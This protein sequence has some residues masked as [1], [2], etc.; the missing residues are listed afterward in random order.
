[1][2]ERDGRMEGKVAMVTGAGSGQGFETALALAKKGA[3]VVMVGR[4]RERMEGPVREV[5]ERSGNG[6]VEV[7]AADLSSMASVGRLAEDFG[8]GHDRLDVLVNNP[9][10][11][12]GE[13]RVTEDGFEEMF[14]VNHLAPFLLTNLL[15]PL[16]RKGA[17]S[18]VV[19]V[20]S[21]AHAMAK[22]DFDDLQ[23]ERRFGL[24]RSYGASK[25]A[26]LLF[27]YE[28]A[29]RLEGSGVTVN[30]LNP[31]LTATAMG[32][33]A[34]TTLPGWYRLAMRLLGPF[35]AG[36]PEEGAATAVYLASSP[37]VEG[38]TGGYFEGG[39]E[40]HSSRASRD[41]VAARRL[42][43]VSEGLVG[44]SGGRAPQAVYGR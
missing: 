30:A 10:V 27:G 42:W 24:F 11:F 3:T 31:G 43:A 33:P 9:G 1:M 41:E 39:E 14:A 37:E 22:I 29:R 26:N 25:L 32:S 40:K 12:D 44:L 13:R 21:S 34:K 20:N 5:R 28:L 23:S 19:N 16:L 6:E 7:L 18:R 36:S 2:E 15:L 4:S 8:A 17:P 35:L 38:A